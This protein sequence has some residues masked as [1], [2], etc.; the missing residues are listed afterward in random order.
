MTSPA[1]SPTKHEWLVILPDHEGVLQKR[2]E[3]RPQHLAGVKPLAEAGAILFGGAFFDDL[4]PDGE[5]PQVKGTV[6]LAYAES[7]E[8]V[9]EQLRQDEYTK[10][11]VWD[12]DR[13]QIYGFKTAL[14]KGLEGGM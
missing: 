5:T 1:P 11:G 13:V 2:L 10:S 7:K 4:P 3:A 12:W 8:K 14:R 9:L 6:L